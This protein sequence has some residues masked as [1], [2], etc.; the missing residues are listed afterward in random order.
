MNFAPFPPRVCVAAL[1]WVTV[2][3]TGAAVE[4]WADGK[5]PV[6]NGLEV[7]LDASAQTE[8]RQVRN[9]SKI[10]DNQPLDVWLD[11]SGH[12][13][14]V[15]QLKPEARPS[16]R[17]KAGSA[18]VRFDGKDDF[19]AA[20]G[21]R[22]SF[23]NAT[24]FVC[25][26]AHA[27][28]GRYRGF[29]AISSAT[30][31]DYTSG[32]NLDLGNQAGAEFTMLNAEGAGF[33][34]AK[35]LL[36]SNLFFGRWHALSVVSAPGTNGV[37]LFADGVAQ[38]KRARNAGVMQ[39]DELTVGARRYS[40][41]AEPPRAQSFL[42][43]DLAEVLIYNRAL[44]NAER[45]QVEKYLAAKYAELRAAPLEAPLTGVRPFNTVSNPPP[46]QMLVPG[47]TARPLP[48]EL[49]NIN[50]VKYRADGK[51]YA[52]GYDGQIWLL[53]D[54]DG[55]GLEDKAELFWDKGGMRG[56]IGLAVTPPGYARGQGVFVPSK[57]KLSLIVDTNG[58]D[59]ADQEI[60]VATGWQEIAQKVDT[61]GVALAPDGS[62]YFALG[63]A[64]YANAYLID[65]TTGVAAYDL[66]S[67]RGTVQRV[68]PDFSRRRRLLAESAASGKTIHL[69][70][71]IVGVD[72]LG[73][74]ATFGTRLP[75]GAKGFDIGPGSA[76]AFSDVIMDA[77][78]VFWN[79]PMG[80][81]E[82]PRFAAGTR[83]VA[84]AMADTKAF[85]VVGGG[86]S[87][88]AL[89][90][91]GLDDEVSHVSTGG[92]ASLELLELGDLPGLD[93]LRKA[94]NA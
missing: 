70:E 52:L 45:G 36:A 67:E 6:A 44:S 88:A 35:N 81:F 4:P 78:T 40:N 47:F 33:G 22:R 21:L 15:S 20:S 16:L 10:P 53:S 54:T 84:Q 91:F 28:P 43:G 83:T 93:A 82:D 85:T 57:G 37:R 94:P 51:L 17:R 86:D 72:A 48:L 42:E 14:D 18:F 66:A 69:P 39:M 61:I 31:N 1:L 2:A 65:K 24:V 30:V 76:A 74:F 79:G 46:V 49:P 5:L 71:D 87:A 77:R 50:N 3:S 7:W 11:G 27:N 73:N 75:D 41:S 32:F 23:S 34:G 8:A 56:P 92:G 29:V 59:R 60:I 89:A 62:V 58:D 80:M 9:L 26:T 12:G 13:F 64:N 55:D 19:L 38:R 25:G 90:Q 63:T 68:T